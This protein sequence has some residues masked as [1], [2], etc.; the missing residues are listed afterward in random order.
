[1]G[2]SNVKRGTDVMRAH[3][4]NKEDFNVKVEDVNWTQASLGGGGGSSPPLAMSTGE[5]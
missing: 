2:N 5:G 3:D 4:V 1:M